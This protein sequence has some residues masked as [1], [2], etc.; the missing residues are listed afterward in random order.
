MVPRMGCASVRY[1]Y[2]IYTI[3]TDMLGSIAHNGSSLGLWCI[4]NSGGDCSLSDDAMKRAAFI[5]DSNFW[6]TAMLFIEWW[7]VIAEVKC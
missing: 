4:Y 3:T 7:H 1:R 5:S 2:Q 6:S